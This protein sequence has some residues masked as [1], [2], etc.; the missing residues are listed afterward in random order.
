V[1]GH[2][3]L[4]LADRVHEPEPVHAEADHADDRDRRQRQ[5]R[6]ER[7]LPA[8]AQAR[9]G[10]H[11]ERE[12]QS[13]RDLHPHAR[14]Q[15]SD[16]RTRARPRSLVSAQR[17]PRRLRRRRRALVRAQRK[18]CGEREQEQ[19]VVVGA[20]HRQHE[21]HRVQ[22]DER[23]RPARGAAR[24]RGRARDQRHGAEAGEDRDRLE[25]PQPASEP[26]R[27]YRVARER[28]QRTVRRVQEG[29]A[30]EV[31]RRV[32]RRFR[33]H[34]RVGIQS[35]QR[36]QPRERQVAEHVLGDQRWPEQ[37]DHVGQ[38]DRARERR[39]RQPSRCHEH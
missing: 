4:L 9:G 39:Q 24:A 26:Q 1:G 30:D 8:L 19:R 5:H 15:R 7:H 2:E 3:L 22:A 12:R 23:R 27:R 32:R 29:P 6:V 11:Q 21:Q 38:H 36:S 16:G 33:G 13:R 10:E 25:R 18:G 31:I 37:E 34:V 35:V 14:R 28:E 20:A 17:S